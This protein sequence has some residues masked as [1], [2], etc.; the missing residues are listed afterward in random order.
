MSIY[1]GDKKITPAIL[2]DARQTTIIANITKNG[3]YNYLAPQGQLYNQVTITVNV[4]E[5]KVE[6][7]K[8]L[9]VTENG[10]Y[11]ILPDA[12]K[13]IS[14]AIVTVNV[15]E[16]KVEQEKTLTVTSNGTYN[17]I[18]DDGKVISKAVVTVNVQPSLQAKSVTPS[19]V[20]QIANPDS[21]Y[22]G[23]SQVTVYAAPTEPVTVTPT[24]GTQTIVPGED[25]VGFS[26]VNVEPIPD[27]YII[28]SGTLQITSNGTYD[29][30]GKANAVVNVEQAKPTLN[31]PSIS[32]SGTTLTITNPASN[33]NFVTS[34]T[35]YNGSTVITTTTSKTINLSDYIK[36][37]GTYTLTVKAKGTNFNDS[38]SSNSVTYTLKSQT[39]PAIS[40]VSGTTIQIDTID[41]NATTIEVFA[42]GTSIGSVSKQ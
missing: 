34:Y 7:E 24:K 2:Y 9:S 17:I 29:V 11:N 27:D 14:K 6:Q 3:E 1:L 42:D 35:L 19:K 30:S 37:A 4:P 41:D 39:T 12:G 13:V 31:A 10:T 28:P 15:P 22:Y 16:Q 23:L 20:Q 33:G 18:P 25:K 21:S 5:Q 26:Q 38:A 32:L 36:T 8:T 40:L